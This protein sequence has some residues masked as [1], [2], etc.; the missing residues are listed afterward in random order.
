MAYND[1]K[2]IEYQQEPKHISFWDSF[3]FPLYFTA[4]IWLIHIFQFVF[5]L[6]L[7]A[8][9]IWPRGAFGLRGILFAPLLHSN[10]EHLA[11]NSVP[12]LVCATM[13]IYFFPR[14]AFRSG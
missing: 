5:N 12:F 3:R 6:D 9:G 14:V 4:V 2:Y 7:G 8:L 10:W 11:S 13:I 1:V